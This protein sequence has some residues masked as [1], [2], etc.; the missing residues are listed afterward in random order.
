MGYVIFIIIPL[1]LFIIS[2]PVAQKILKDGQK[3]TL[4][5][6]CRIF[7]I[8]SIVAGTL[9]ICLSHYFD[10]L[11][12]LLFGLNRYTIYEPVYMELV[13]CVLLALTGINFA[14]CGIYIGKNVKHD[15]GFFVS[16]LGLV[17]N[18]AIFIFFSWNVWAGKLS[19]VY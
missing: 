17:Y 19:V 9:T 11:G 7:G 1:I 3:I 13:S 16:A 6:G 15:F 12:R 2:V 4:S 5:Y 18:L 10:L 8:F 14:T